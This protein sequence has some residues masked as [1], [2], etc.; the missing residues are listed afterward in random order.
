MTPTGEEDVKCSTSPTVP[1]DLGFNDCYHHRD[2]VAPS[3]S[4]SPPS[5]TPG[6]QEEAFSEAFSEEEAFSNSSDDDDEER[7]F[8]L[9]L[10]SLGRSQQ[11]LLTNLRGVRDVQS[12]RWMADGSTTLLS[13]SGDS[14]TAQCSFG[15]DDSP[16]GIDDFVTLG[17]QPIEKRNGLRSE[18]YLSGASPDTGSDG[19]PKR[20]DR[21]KRT[22]AV[23]ALKAFRKGIQ[24]M[25]CRTSEASKVAA[26]SFSL[27]AKSSRVEPDGRMSYTSEATSASSASTAHKMFEDLRDSPQSAARTRGQHVSPTARSAPKQNAS[28]CYGEP[29]IYSSEETPSP[30]PLWRRRS[31]REKM[32]ALPDIRATS[33]PSGSPSEAPQEAWSPLSDGHARGQPQGVRRDSDERRHK[34]FDLAVLPSRSYRRDNGEMSPDSSGSH[35]ARDARPRFSQANRPARPRC[36]SASS[37]VRMRLNCSQLSS[38]VAFGERAPADVQGSPPRHVRPRGRSTRAPTMEAL[39]SQICNQLAKEVPTRRH[40][41][42]TL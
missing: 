12:I 11:Q 8:P 38:S 37:D 14:T 21:R 6:D 22:R 19:L 31:E 23:K 10:P 16:R 1:R 9:S 36:D 32:A 27:P 24:D 3:L 30:P 33:L 39:Q 29:A 28:Y 2:M 5:L 18:L 40:C 20:V 41:T 13:G 15:C 34:S 17:G 26:V 4:T 42:P 35:S 25:V 7:C